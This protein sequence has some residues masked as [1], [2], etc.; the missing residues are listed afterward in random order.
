[1][2]DDAKKNV[3]VHCLLCWTEFVTSEES[4]EKDEVTCPADGCGST[5]VRLKV[6]E[7]E[8]SD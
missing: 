5:L 8:G 2:T 7:D 4:Y 3:A 1:M 6:A